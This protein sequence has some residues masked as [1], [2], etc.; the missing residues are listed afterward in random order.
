VWILD[1]IGATACLYL[2][3]CAAVAAA[4]AGAKAK[5]KVVAVAF[6]AEVTLSAGVDTVNRGRRKA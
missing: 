5:A 1:A 6:I 4:V 2:R 3:A